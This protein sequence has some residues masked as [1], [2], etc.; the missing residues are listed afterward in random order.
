MGADFVVHF[1]INVRQKLRTNS[2]QIQAHMFL[3][4]I[5]CTGEGVVAGATEPKFFLKN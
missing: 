3:P 4:R 5:L 1:P 2:D